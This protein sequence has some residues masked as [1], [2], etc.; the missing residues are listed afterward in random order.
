[1]ESLEGLGIFV[2]QAEV[3]LQTTGLATQLL[4]IKDQHERL[5]KLIETMESDKY[6]IKEAVRAIQELDFG[7]DIVAPIITLKK[8]CKTVTSTPSKKRYE[9][10]KN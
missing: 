4:N 3:S 6:T 7:E 9:Q 1:M 10:S 5:V 8:E 2:T